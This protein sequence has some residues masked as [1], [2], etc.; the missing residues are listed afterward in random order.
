MEGRVLLRL[1]PHHPLAGAE[2]LLA[3][4][5]DR[6][7]VFDPRTRLRFVLPLDRLHSV[8]DGYAGGQCVDFEGQ[9]PRPE[10]TVRAGH[11]KAVRVTAT[12]SHRYLPE[13]GRPGAWTLRHRISIDGL[14]GPRPPFSP[15]PQPLLHVALP[16]F[17][18][19]EGRLAL[20]TLGFHSGEPAAWSTTVI[21]EGGSERISPT[22]RATVERGGRV[23]LPVQR[24]LAERAGFRD[25]KTLLP[26]P[27]ARGLQRVKA[28]SLAGLR[29]SKGTGSVTVRNRSRYSALVFLDAV[30]LGWVAPR[31]E[32]TFEGVPVGY[33]RLYAVSPTG[34][35]QWGPSDSYVPGP[36]TLR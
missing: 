5:L 11:Q 27:S 30:L 34:T 35:R 24:M 18:T 31:G 26:A 13:A 7:F 6:L 15:F 29:S 17:Q 32:L 36:W 23:R 33:Y 3:E 14:D 2:L 20:Q 8:L 1:S 19:P 25:A 28:A 4:D 10:G 16:T 22:F 21:R 9:T 12:L